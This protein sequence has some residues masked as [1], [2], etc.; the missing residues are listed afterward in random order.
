MMK[1]FQRAGSL[2]MQYNRTGEDG[3]E[4]RRQILEELLG[5]CVEKASSYCSKH[6]VHDRF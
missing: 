4:L 3:Q 5:K 2:C 6:D 1:K